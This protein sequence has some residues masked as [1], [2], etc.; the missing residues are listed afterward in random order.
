M[1]RLKVNQLMY[2]V[3]IQGWK[4]A[5]AE[6][7]RFKY[8]VDAEGNTAESREIKEN[9]GKALL[10]VVFGFLT[11][12]V[13][14]EIVNTILSGFKPSEVIPKEVAS[15]IANQFLSGVKTGLQYL[16]N[17]SF[18]DVAGDLQ[19]LKHSLLPEVSWRTSFNRVL[20]NEAEKTSPNAGEET[21]H[22]TTNEI[23]QVLELKKSMFP[24]KSKAV[25]WAVDN[26]YK[27][28]TMTE[29]ATYYNINQVANPVRSGK[30]VHRKAIHEGF[31]LL[32]PTAP[33]KPET[34][35]NGVLKDV[36]EKVGT[37]TAHEKR[38]R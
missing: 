31:V 36:A 8:D 7:N 11:G 13:N 23:P 38:D 19:K 37:E 17:S 33:K 25:K 20:K 35:I 26:G 27:H 21:T 9:F 30:G 14:S 18:S 12:K 1:D 34:Y 5:N 3:A 29:T 15:T 10:Q 2:E 4:K 6:I 28:G 24:T 22:E 16:T 32:L